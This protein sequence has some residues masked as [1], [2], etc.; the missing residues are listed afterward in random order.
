MNVRFTWLAWLH[1]LYG[2][3]VLDFVFVFISLY[4]LV[5][6]FYLLIFRKLH[7][8]NHHIHFVFIYLFINLF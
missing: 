7:E 5:L 2:L 1:S 6:F 4:L 8:L 3:H